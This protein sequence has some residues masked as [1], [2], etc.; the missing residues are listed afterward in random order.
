MKRSVSLVLIVA[1][2]CV[3]LCGC[4][5]QPL[6]LYAKDCL[7]RACD[8]PTRMPPTVFCVTNPSYAIA[9]IG[10]DLVDALR[11][12]EWV[13]YEDEERVFDDRAMTTI[14]V[15]TDSDDQL[16]IKVGKEYGA[17]GRF[18]DKFLPIGDQL[19]SIPI[20]KDTYY[21]LPQEADGELFA[22]VDALAERYVNLANGGKNPL[23]D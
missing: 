14:F 5:T 12:D 10:Q 3:T 9:P 22:V 13:L 7:Q 8:D 23:S 11:L 6:S 20:E 15:E 17:I 21:R 1:L 19:G 2:I 18:E 16:T 4:N